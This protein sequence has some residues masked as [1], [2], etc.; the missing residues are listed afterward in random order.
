MVGELM[1]QCS[2]QVEL[3]MDKICAQGCELVSAYIMAL[4][5]DESRPEFARLDATQRAARLFELQAI[6][7]VYEG[8]GFLAGACRALALVFQQQFLANPDAFGR[9]FHQFIFV[10][11]F[12]CLFE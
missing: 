12:Q 3:A 7:A 2:P 4:K 11:E 10:D 8:K 1:K 6:M 5:K 9:D